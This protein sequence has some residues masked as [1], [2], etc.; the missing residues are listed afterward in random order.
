MSPSVE[1][2]SVVTGVGRTAVAQAVPCNDGVLCGRSQEKYGHGAVC[3]Y[4]VIAVDWRRQRE[5]A[6][7]HPLV[8]RPKE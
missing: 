1:G 6:I 4:Q 2:A 3:P 8:S 7:C 5:R